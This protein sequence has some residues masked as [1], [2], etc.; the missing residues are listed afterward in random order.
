MDDILEGKELEFD[1][2][3]EY[4]ET[5]EYTGIID[6][7][8][9]A[10]H[11]PEVLLEFSDS[12]E[13]GM[14]QTFSSVY[15]RLC[16][17]GMEQQSVLLSDC[18]EALNRGCE[19]I[20]RELGECTEQEITARIEVCLSENGCVIA[21]VDNEDWKAWKDMEASLFMDSGIRV[22]E[23]A[24]IV[25]TCIVANDAADGDKDFVMVPLSDFS[26]MNGLLLEVLK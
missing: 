19:V 5:D 21:A 2:F 25:D 22:I 11:R 18:L 20:K 17:S 14:N 24:G 23:I 9:I 26:A 15:E 8:N 10:G 1:W 16:G 6:L 13:A 7:S 3:P 12:L 4:K